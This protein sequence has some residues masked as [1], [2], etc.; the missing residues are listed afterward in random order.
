MLPKTPINIQMNMG[1]K[2]SKPSSSLPCNCD[3]IIRLTLD[4]GTMSGLSQAF[5]LIAS[6]DFRV[7][8]PCHLFSMYML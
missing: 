1:L 5:H 7:Y 3:V 6:S 2:D 4:L 8:V